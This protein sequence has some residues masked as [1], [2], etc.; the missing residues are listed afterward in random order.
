MGQDMNNNVVAGRNVVIMRPAIKYHCNGRTYTHK[1]K[2]TTAINS[3]QM[4]TNMTSEYEAMLM[5]ES[6]NPVEIPSSSNDA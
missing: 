6:D 5:D 4:F 2:R 3:K 1:L